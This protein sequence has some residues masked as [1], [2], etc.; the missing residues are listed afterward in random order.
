MMMVVWWRRQW[1]QWQQ[2]SKNNAARPKMTL[3]LTTRTGNGDEHDHNKDW[4]RHQHPTVTIK[5]NRNNITFNIRIIIKDNDDETKSPTYIYIHILIYDIS[6]NNNIKMA[7]TVV[8]IFIIFINHQQ[9]LNRIQS[10]KPTTSHQSK[11]HC[12][13]KQKNEDT[14]WFV[15]QCINSWL[16]GY[17]DT[18]PQPRQPIRL[19]A[20][21]KSTFDSFI[22]NQ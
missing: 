16:H 10:W 17:D 7:T 19:L 20:K 6:I 1:L 15:K 9:Q 3:V 21:C 4:H 2:P 5:V 12:F 11:Q 22:S 18:C 13:S 8:I 14:Q